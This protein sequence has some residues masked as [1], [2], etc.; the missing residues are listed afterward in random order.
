V[1]GNVIHKGGIRKEHGKLSSD[2]AGSFSNDFLRQNPVAI[3]KNALC[4]E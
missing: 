2:G 1:N 3:N 4:L